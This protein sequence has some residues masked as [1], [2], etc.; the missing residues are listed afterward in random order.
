LSFQWS[1]TMKRLTNLITLM[2]VR[3]SRKPSPKF[4][5]LF[6]KLHIAFSLRSYFS[7]NNFKFINR[8]TINILCLKILLEYCIA[9]VVVSACP[10]KTN[11]FNVWKFGVLN[12]F[13]KIFILLFAIHSFRFNASN[14]VVAYTHVLMVSVFK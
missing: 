13:F 9:I 3:K 5:R 8:L 6:L 2:K 14:V 7:N 1:L 4:S 10:F 11:V 12:C